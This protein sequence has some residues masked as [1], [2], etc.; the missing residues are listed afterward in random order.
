MLVFGFVKQ[1][2][3]LLI[4]T[5]RYLKEMMSWKGWLDEE[6]KFVADLSKIPE[7]RKGTMDTGFGVEGS[8]RQLDLN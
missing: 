2:Y 5:E 1:K 4:I 6:N 7:D 3:L 8:F